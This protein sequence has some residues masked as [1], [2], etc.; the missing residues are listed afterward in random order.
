[1]GL[2]MILLVYFDFKIL[3]MKVLENLIY[4]CLLNLNLLNVGYLFC[5]FGINR[6]FVIMFFLLC[7]NMDELDSI[8]LWLI[9]I[10]FFE[11]LISNFIY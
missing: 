8:D 5:E 7:D 2:D 10:V 1:M 6:V 4:K 11:F 9:E 3:Y